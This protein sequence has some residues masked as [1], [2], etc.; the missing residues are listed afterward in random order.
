MDFMVKFSG[1]QSDG[2]DTSSSIQNSSALISNYNN[3]Q[4]N[5]TS[6]STVDGGCELL[7]NF[8]YIIQGI[9]G[10]LSFA[11]L[12]CKVYRGN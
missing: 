12:V 6:N 3:T 10:I 5:H 8:G 7:G 4:M 2:Y 9:L 11:V 1:S